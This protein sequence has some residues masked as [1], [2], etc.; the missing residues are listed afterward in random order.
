M[1]GSKAKEAVK[2]AGVGE[3]EKEERLAKELGKEMEF[4]VN[5]LAETIEKDTKELEKEE[6]EQKK[7]ITMDDLHDGF[8]SKV[9]KHRP[10]SS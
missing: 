7:H 10:P 9:R 3:A 8:E 6:A 2:E 4:H 5:N 1:V